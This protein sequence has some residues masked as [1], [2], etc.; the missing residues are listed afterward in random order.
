ME[1]GVGV[2]LPPVCEPLPEGPRSVGNVHAGLGELDPA[3]DCLE[4]A[5]EERS[6][7]LVGLR[8]PHLFGM[9]HTDPRHEDL[10]RRVGL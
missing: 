5:V 7:W 4:R 8:S 1:R 2:G 6:G 9:L 10:C 3:F